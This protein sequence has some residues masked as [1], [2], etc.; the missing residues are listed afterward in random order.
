M[1]I[2]HTSDWH[3]VARL[4]NISRSD[5]QAAFLRWLAATIRE[6]SVDLLLIAGDLYDRFSP[7]NEAQ[8]L[9]FDFLRE[10]RDTSPKTET[11]VVAGNH[12]SASFIDAPSALLRE[13]RVYTVGTIG[14]ERGDW[15]RCIIPIGLAE[16][17]DNAQAAPRCVV[18]AVPYVP[19][20]LLDI[21]LGE[22]DATT[23][24]ASYNRAF[25]ELYTVLSREAAERFPGAPQIA[26]GHL[27]VGSTS[28]DDYHTPIH[29]VG[30][31]NNLD[32]TIFGDH[33]AYV[34][35]GHLHRA[36]PVGASHIRYAGTP[37]PLN[38]HEAKTPRFVTLV[39]LDEG[40][41][42]QRA[43]HVEQRE[44][45]SLRQIVVLRGD[46]KELNA[47]LRALPRDPDF[48]PIAYA[49]A[50]VEAYD[51]GLQERLLETCM[52]LGEG[53]PILVRV[54]QMLP[55]VEADESTTTHVRSLAD[56]SP[57]D[58]FAM[59]YER[60]RKTLPPSEIR[61][62]F[63]SLLRATPEAD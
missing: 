53:H 38:A 46:E 62:A 30:T 23:L 32:P 41:T 12:D 37:V 51:A 44:V 16:E 28:S 58:V 25:A 7:S 54:T 39:E 56:H 49:E 13:L 9:Y 4:E 40:D 52:S 5:E 19:E 36:H 50:H 35:L 3:L 27:T 45:P 33:F 20:Y 14:R 10:L 57:E 61:D 34:A 22:N 18:I 31:I 48:P 24:K 21:P 55:E 47:Q 42:A 11:V 8:R 1:R 2:L 63:A 15:E 43:V 6:E 59:L 29:S 17:S 60:Q 26:T